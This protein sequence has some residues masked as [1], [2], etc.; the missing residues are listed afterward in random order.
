MTQINQDIPWVGDPRRTEM[1]TPDD[2][3]AMIRLRQLGWG[4]K[5]IAAELGCSK[6]TSNPCLLLHGLDLVS[7][8]SNWAQRSALIRFESRPRLSSIQMTR[9]S[10]A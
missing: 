5:R 1:R 3:S 4:P 9:F 8:A 10:N 6:N 7:T 2:V